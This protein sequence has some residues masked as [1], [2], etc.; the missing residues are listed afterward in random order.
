MAI[1]PHSM[2]DYDLYLKKGIVM[3]Y[4]SKRQRYHG[5]IFPLSPDIVHSGLALRS[6]GTQV[7]QS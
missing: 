2:E 3:L 1:L 7:Q 5:I 6:L 4:A